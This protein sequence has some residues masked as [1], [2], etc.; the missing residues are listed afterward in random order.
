MNDNLEIMGDMIEDSN[1]DNK[2]ESKPKRYGV[3]TILDSE[4]YDNA[5]DLC[6]DYLFEGLVPAVCTTCGYTTHYEPDSTAG[7]CEEC[8]TG[9][10]KSIFILL[11]LI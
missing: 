7:W 9:T 8:D 1:N 6:E 5:E 10:C 4:G 2:P 3:S 11:G